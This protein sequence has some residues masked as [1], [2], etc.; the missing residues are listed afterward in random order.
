LARCALASLTFVLKDLFD[1]IL[2]GLEI[3]Q[4]VKQGSR[5][6]LRKPPDKPS[7]GFGEP[8]PISTTI[9]PISRVPHQL[10]MDDPASLSNFAEIATTHLHLDWSIDWQRRVIYG[11]V[12]HTLEKRNPDVK[13]VVFDTSFLEIQSVSVDGSDAKACPS[14]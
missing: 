10:S 9:S 7:S 2:T 12:T 8:S 4:M 11:S 14:F 3:R 5:C 6:G 1:G 13:E